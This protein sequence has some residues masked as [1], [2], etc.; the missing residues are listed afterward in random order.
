MK[1]RDGILAA[2][3]G[4]LLGL[5]LLALFPAALAAQEEG[6]EFR[7]SNFSLEF[8]GGVCQV[9]P[10]DLN[11]HPIYEEATLQFYWVQY[12]NYLHS[13]YGDNFVVSSTRTGD[14]T[15]QT[16]K[17]ATPYGFRLRY[18]ASPTLALTLG[19]QYLNGTQV[20][21]VGMTFD[22]Q[23]HRPG[24]P[25][26]SAIRTAQYQNSGFT[27]QAKAWMPE[28]GAHFGW[29]LMTAL[30]WEISISFGPIFA[31]CR[32][33]TQRHSII[34][35]TDGFQSDNGYAQELKGSITGLGGE[36]GTGLFIRPMKH[37][38]VFVEGGYIFRELGELTG[39]GSSTTTY[40]DSNAV[41]NE[42]RSSWT[43]EWLLQVSD[44]TK[45]WG[46]FTS[47]YIQN[48]STT[49]PGVRR[50]NPDLSG[51]Q[52]KTGVGFNF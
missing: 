50:F 20:S 45:S 49:I 7:Q 6:Y 40:K 13:L 17:R 5:I 41:S 42:A 12:Y 34:T 25:D 8:Y 21:N 16:I 28:L 14:A 35:T 26:S 29:D 46:R 10:E 39:S 11:H 27:T 2:L 1:R 44:V 51:F 43:G 19:I 23:D 15:F 32:T 33:L 48:Q 18:Q 4:P 30:R 36:L 52:V 9:N 31:Q 38:R 37:L 24:L 22:I 47:I 3:S